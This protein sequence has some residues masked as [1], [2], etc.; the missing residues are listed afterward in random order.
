MWR[1]KEGSCQKIAY[2]TRKTTYSNRKLPYIPLINTLLLILIHLLLIIVVFNIGYLI[3]Y[4]KSIFVATLV[5]YVESL[6][7]LL[8]LC[9]VFR[10]LCV[11]FWGFV[12]SVGALYRLVGL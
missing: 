4:V 9:I 12:L 5:K 7:N 6:S 10:G 3:F 1:L 11:V 2:F 8:C